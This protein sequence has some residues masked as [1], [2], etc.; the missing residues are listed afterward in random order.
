MLYSKEPR[1]WSKKS[2]SHGPFVPGT[3]IGSTQIDAIGQ[4]RQRLGRELHLRPLG[5]GDPRPGKCSLFQ[6]L[7]H[8]PKSGSIPIEDLQP[9][10]S[11][12]D[13]HEERTRPR[14]FLQAFCHQTV[15]AI[16]TLAQVRAAAP[17]R[18]S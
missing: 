8:D 5:F 18:P 2:L 7:G 1:P 13:E 11:L 17:Q 6:T 3:H 14:V 9:I 15:Q 12:A 4:K 16:K 10:M